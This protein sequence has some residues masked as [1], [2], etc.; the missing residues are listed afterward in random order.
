MIHGLQLVNIGCHT[1]TQLTFGPL[2]AIV[3]QNGTGKTTILKA[4]EKIVL[5]WIAPKD[6]TQPPIRNFEAK[7]SRNG[8]LGSSVVAINFWTPPFES[9]SHGI[10]RVWCTFGAKV[11][12]IEDKDRGGFQTV[13]DDAAWF[14]RYCT[15]D[16]TPPMRDF[17]LR[18]WQD[19]ETKSLS[20]NSLFFYNLG[21]FED[22]DEKIPEVERLVS[23]G[24][25][26]THENLSRYCEL[27]DCTYLKVHLEELRMPSYSS[28]IQ[29]KLGADGSM[30]STVLANLMTSDRLLFEEIVQALREVV[31]VIKDIK[32][33]RCPVTVR[34]PAT[35][36]VKGREVVYSDEREFQGHQLRFDTESGNDLPAS[37]ISDGTLY[38]LALITLI[39]TSGPLSLI[40]LDDVELGLHPAAQRNLVR[41]LKALQEQ[42]LCQIILT[43]HSPYVIDELEAD[44]VWLLNHAKNG[45]VA[46]RKLS[47]H[48][49][50]KE[51]LSVLTTGEFWSSEGEDW[52]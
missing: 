47:D 34:E 41:Q 37:A 17:S 7:W 45:T 49:R 6:K 38:V 30:L 39:H 42:H 13:I 29:P 14:V 9:E 52:L 19:E 21:D 5:G 15:S 27:S 44:Q 1:Q 36:T 11:H 20:G 46:A 35:V 25:F 8:L 3:G 2:T 28:E 31:P 40:L 22:N 16:E 32:A 43:T 10:E 4:L 26:K 51:A 23:L 50:A 33:K 48:P 24:D 12:S 18:N